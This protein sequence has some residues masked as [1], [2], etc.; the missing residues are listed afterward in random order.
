M[1]FL[2]FSPKG[3]GF[4][5]ADTLAYAG[6]PQGIAEFE[7]PPTLRAGG[8]KVAV[9][10][11]AAKSARE[12]NLRARYRAAVANVHG[13]M[14]FIGLPAAA[15]TR[16]NV[17]VQEL[18]VPL[19]LRQGSQ[20][21]TEKGSLAT[22]ELLRQL[23]PV[24]RP[25]PATNPAKLFV[26][27][28]REI[29]SI[30]GKGARF[31]VLGEPGSG[32]TTLCRFAAA[33]FTGV[34]S[35]AE[36]LPLF[37]T[38]RDYVRSCRDQ[39]D[40]SL[41]A[42]LAGQAK[43]HLQVGGIDED[44][45]EKVLQAGDVVLL[46]DGLDEVGSAEEREKMRD[47]VLAF[48]SQYPK[49][50]VLLTSRFAGYDEAP[51]PSGEF[52]RLELLPFEN[53]DLR[54]F[55]HN[56]YAA[57]EPND[58]LARQ[59]GSADLLAA[60]EAE[61]R[62]KA[63]AGNP[64]LATLIALVHRSEAKLPG[65]R[66][67]LY[68]KVV[69][70]LLET[71]PSQAKRNFREIDEGLQRSY[72]ESF[73]LERQKKRNRPEAEVSFRRAELVESLADLHCRQAGVAAA[74]AKRQVEQWVD[75]LAAG[76]GILVEQ[77]PGVFAFLHL[78]LLEYLA[79]CALDREKEPLEEAVTRL[80]GEPV[81]REALLLAVGRHDTDLSFLERL[82][83][84]LK[85]KG[86]WFFLVACLREE[87]AFDAGKRASILDAASRRLLALR[88]E[89]LDDV[90]KVVRTIERFSQRHREGTIL[91]R[92]TQLSTATGEGLRGVVALGVGLDRESDLRLLSARRDGAMA[93]TELLGFWP[94]SPVGQWAVQQ[95]AAERIVALFEEAPADLGAARVLAVLNSE[96]PAFW[97]SALSGL[98]LRTTRHFMLLAL[99][100]AAGFKN[101]DREG[102][103]GLPPEVQM[104]AGPH[105]V[106]LNV[107]PAWPRKLSQSRVGS[108]IWTDRCL[109]L[110]FP[111][112]FVRGFAFEFDL[113]F[114]RYL[115][116][117][118][119][120][121]AAA[122][123]SR[124]FTLNFTR[125]F[126]SNFVE[127]FFREFFEASVG[128]YI[129]YPTQIFKEEI[130]GVKGEI[131]RELALHSA[132]HFPAYFAES[133]KFERALEFDSLVRLGKIAPIQVMGSADRKA[134]TE[135]VSS[136]RLSAITTRRAGEAWIA[137][138]TTAQRS[139]EEAESYFSYRLQNLSL[140]YLWPAIDEKL[141]AEPSPEKLALY[142]ELGWTQ[143]TTT[144]DWP[145][146]PRWIA[147]L[148]GKP[149]AHWLPRAHW[150]LCWLLYQPDATS[151]QEGF[152]AALRE[153]LAETDVSLRAAAETLEREMG[154]FE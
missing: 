64:L 96:A 32:K 60:L 133:F 142:L 40:C 146:T 99:E 47:R 59:R 129:R 101:S 122:N 6:A 110:D 135:V 114:A 36:P 109:A 147:L 106:V 131:K 38:F 84:G 79:A 68:E 115:T 15:G 46:L 137:L 16:P 90:A 50:S 138:A 150:H 63:L 105:R 77:Q 141:P 76:T 144:H 91:W 85:A 154:F 120:R 23:E 117:D 70:L 95:V 52:E 126:S 127:D 75:Y 18:F 102:G 27:M 148:K 45:F 78:S 48:C 12:R 28:I 128:Y 44:W 71:W 58:P 20:P 94:G 143:A 7:L 72:L 13:Q 19:R 88:V 54:V 25:E 124:H 22:A 30:G 29:F 80:E 113:D 123:F 107:L 92:E 53:E 4:W 69:Q 145:G 37:L 134:W 93:A 73:A 100:A 8:E 111:W 9:A 26:G 3:G 104:V 108:F 82:F 103:T 55:V 31:V 81:W 1:E 149:P 11:R 125:Y 98:R 112:H 136:S 97:A 5:A 34:E 10:G 2:A 17:G 132:L 43:S 39:G 41:L 121:N 14:R 51:L 24:P 89:L 140:L 74:V 130:A 49:L 61:P 87:A 33:H 62:V 151:Y 21:G 116:A 139:R 153:G 57:Q 67:K 118:F 35:T 86:A 152:N 66:A 119:A 56:W 42:F 65:E 83:T